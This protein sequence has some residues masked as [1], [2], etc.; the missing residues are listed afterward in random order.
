MPGR[1]SKLAPLLSTYDLKLA[2]AQCSVKEKE[3][4]YT[5]KPVSHQC[6]RN[7]LLCKTKVGGKWR[8]VS[9]RPTFPNPSQYV[10]CYF[11]VEGSGCT[12]HRNRCTFARSDEE[13]AIWTFEKHHRLDHVLLCNLIAQSEKGS[14]LPDNSEPLGD[15]LPTLDLK[16]VCDLCSIKEKEITYKVQ[17]LS[18]KC[19]RN[20]LLAKDKASN[21]WRPVCDRPT[22]GFFG[23]NVFYQVCNYFIEGSGCTQHGQGCTYA[24][25][26]E[27]ATVWNYVKDNGISKD[28]LIRLVTES[29]P[30]SPT[31]ESAAKSI[32]QQCSGEFIEFCKECYH[33]RPQK[34][35]TKRWNSTCSGDAAHIWDPVLVHHLSENSRKHIYSQVRPL[36][37]NCQFKYCSHVR[38]GKPCWHQAGH[39]QSA[40][41]EVEMAVWKAEHS[42]LSVRSHLLQLSRQEQTEPRQATM[43]CKVCLLVL[44]SPESFYKHCTSLEHAQLLSEDTT[45]KWRGRQPPHNH[46]SQF[47]LCD[48]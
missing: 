8:P 21:Q 14:D 7:L 23:R 18:H 44:P 30:N 34:L 41:S 32:L 3:I 28:D 5:L 12:H 45:T 26:Y 19:S 11:F 38:E 4:T 39:C 40:Q 16:A 48:R 47:W 10:S 46:Q 13:A 6:A 31:P 20:L 22:G 2:C 1:E 15:L 33:D 37:P 43:Y 17:S 35:T 9:R 36:R 25:S 24:R 29:E 27:E 42:G